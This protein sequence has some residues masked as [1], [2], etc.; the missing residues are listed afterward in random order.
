M[1]KFNR[2]KK[3]HHPFD[4]LAQRYGL[5]REEIKFVANK[6]LQWDEDESKT[7]KQIYIEVEQGLLDMGLITEED[8][9]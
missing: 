1:N 6:C 4:Q 9:K 2:Q 8:M 7:F 3:V 5:K